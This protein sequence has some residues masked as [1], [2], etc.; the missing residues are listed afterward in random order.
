MGDSF[1]APAMGVHFGLNFVSGGICEVSVI[2]SVAACNREAS[3][4]AGA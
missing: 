4:I 1:V 3:C 2:K